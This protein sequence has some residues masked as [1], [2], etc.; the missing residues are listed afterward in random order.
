MLYKA[1]IRLRVSG[2]KFAAGDIVP[3]QKGKSKD[4]FSKEEIAEMLEKG[5][6]YDAEAELMKE[7]PPV[8]S[9]T[10]GATPSDN[11]E[12]NEDPDGEGK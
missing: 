5:Y 10:S 8:T 3:H 12:E 6:I 1:K 11:G 7:V 2:Y 9:V 4:G